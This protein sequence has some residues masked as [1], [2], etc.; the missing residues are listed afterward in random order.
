MWLEPA[1]QQPLNQLEGRWGTA[2]EAALMAW[3]K[4]LS[5]VRVTSA[6]TGP[7]SYFATTTAT[8]TSWFGVAC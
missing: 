4:I 1:N 8:A 2:L 7:Y 6:N 3:E 5:I